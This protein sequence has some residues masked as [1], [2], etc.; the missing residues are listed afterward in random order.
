MTRIEHTPSKLRRLW[1]MKINQM[2]LDTVLHHKMYILIDDIYNVITHNY[3][4]LDRYNRL[5]QG[6]YTANK[7]IIKLKKEITSY[8][9]TQEMIKKRFNDNLKIPIQ[10]KVYYEQDNAQEIL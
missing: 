7:N 3:I 4:H 5:L 10:S 6:R 9:R 1:Y 8:K 2:N